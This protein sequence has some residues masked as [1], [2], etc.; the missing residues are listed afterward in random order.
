M[1]TIEQARQSLLA[2]VGRILSEA[3][4][5]LDDRFIELGGTSF[6]ALQLTFEFSERTGWSIDLAQLLALSLGEV[7]LRL[8]RPTA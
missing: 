4:V 3:D 6:L 1:H 7:E 2:E 8:E 5:R